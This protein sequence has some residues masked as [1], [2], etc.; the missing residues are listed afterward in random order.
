MRVAASSPAWLT[1]RADSRNFCISGV[2]GAVCFACGE[3]STSAGWPETEMD[4]LQVMEKWRGE[5]CGKPDLV[6]DVMMKRELRMAV[7][8]NK[9]DVMMAKVLVC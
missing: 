7:L 1:R 2:R 6:A 3:A 8:G 5:K 9:R 4:L